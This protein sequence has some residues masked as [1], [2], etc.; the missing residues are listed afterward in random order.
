MHPTAESVSACEVE[1]EIL[2]AFFA[3]KKR[4]LGSTSEVVRVVRGDPLFNGGLGEGVRHE[5][6]E[7][8]VIGI[9]ALLGGV[10]AICNRNHSKWVRQ[11]SKVKTIHGA[12]S[13]RT[14]QQRVRI[15]KV[16]HDGRYH[17]GLQGDNAVA[18][19]KSGLADPKQ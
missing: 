2:V 1:C 3:E 19:I 12:I 6:H 18:E 11:W 17:L 16:L 4:H 15:E 13:E 7:L 14:V 5:E 8:A 10:P 9:A